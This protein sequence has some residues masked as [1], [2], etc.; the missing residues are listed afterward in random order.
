MKNKSMTDF[1]LVNILLIFGMTV[2]LVVSTS[3]SQMISASFQEGSPGS[4]ASNLNQ[5]AIDH[6][7]QAQSSLQNGDTEGAQRSMDLAKNAL[8][9]PE[10]EPTN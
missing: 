9:C 4:N 1:R 6:I 2:A 5:E 3:S 7:N 10:C 8:H